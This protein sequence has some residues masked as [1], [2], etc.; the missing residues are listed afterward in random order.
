VGKV[1]IL[2]FALVFE[3]SSPS[4]PAKLAGADGFLVMYKFLHKVSPLFIYNP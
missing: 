4:T 3:I 2:A 1:K